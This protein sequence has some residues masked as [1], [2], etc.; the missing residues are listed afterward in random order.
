MPPAGKPKGSDEFPVS[1]VRD[2]IGDFHLGAHI[3]GVFVKFVSLS[4]AHCAAIAA[5]AVTTAEGSSSSD[6]EEA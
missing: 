3:G 1:V 2:S 4:K 5:K 6:G